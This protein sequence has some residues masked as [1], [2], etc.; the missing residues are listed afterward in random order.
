MLW[1]R[2]LIPDDLRTSYAS[3]RF[4]LCAVAQFRG[5]QRTRLAAQ[6]AALDFGLLGLA[7]YVTLSYRT[8][9]LLSEVEP[10]ARYWV[11]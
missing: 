9:V 2:N 10:D 7:G 8:N 6:Q 1:R 3:G 5:G 11:P 4:E